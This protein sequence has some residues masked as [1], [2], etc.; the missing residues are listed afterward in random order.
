MDF[1]LNLPV[2][3][4]SGENCVTENASVFASFGKK[5]L[6]VTGGKSAL[7]SGALNDCENALRSV[8]VDFKVYSQIGP[9]PRLDA[10]FE[11]SVAARENNCDF[12]VGIGGGS[13]LDAA[14]AVAVYAANESFEPDD[15]YSSA[16][17]KR[18]LP[19]LLIGTT[20]GTGSE[21]S[22]VS[23]LTH[24]ETGRKKSISPEDC[25]AAVSF[26]D[27]R[28][29]HSMPYSVTVSTA[30]DAMAHAIEGYMSDKCGSI[31]TLFGDMAVSLIWKGLE[32]LARTKALPDDLGRKELY[33][34]SL[35]AGVVLAY[36]GTAF[37][38]PMGYILTENYD[39][40]HGM[41]CAAFMDTFIERSEKYKRE[42]FE[43][44]LKAMGTDKDSFV[45]VIRELTD[46]G[47]VIMTQAE[48]EKFC[49]RFETAPANFKFS[50]GG[51]TKEDAL[52]DLVKKFVK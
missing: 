48:A 1:N 2:R 37:P 21:I 34:G 26:A 52:E 32:S 41:A 19:I 38:H 10:C 31:P 49:E 51:F 23:V 40:P 43:Q 3:V 28:Y 39:V 22:R 33:Y 50:P 18:A 47:D 4:I 30:L 29:T 46:V 27:S 25:Y 13:A 16:Q 44:M 36:C 45:R 5:C 24:P 6:I 12:I 42:R 17:R 20:S 14:K 35:Y 9:N 11:A 8:G 7:L 15:I